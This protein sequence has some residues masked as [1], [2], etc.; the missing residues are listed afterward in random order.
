MPRPQRLT[1]RFPARMTEAGYRRLR[2]FA[3]EAGLD[4]GEALSF[5]FE[6]FD[7]VTHRDNL[8]HRLDLH[9][10]MLAKRGDTGA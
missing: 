6:N 1:R 5:L 7:S 10:A 3:E 2:K 9:L 8:M 4:E